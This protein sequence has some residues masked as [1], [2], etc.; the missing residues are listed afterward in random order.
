MLE[1][2]PRGFD[3]LAVQLRGRLLQGSVPKARASCWS[4]WSSQAAD[5][6]KEGTNVRAA[7]EM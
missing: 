7:M 5:L 4:S 6:Q 3:E 1:N 2:I